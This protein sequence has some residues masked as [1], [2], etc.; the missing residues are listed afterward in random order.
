MIYKEIDGQNFLDMIITASNRLEEKKAYVDSLN[1]FPVP[2]GDTGTNMSM[3]F[4]AAVESIKDSKETSLGKISR[5]MAKGALMG[6]RG[7]SGVILSQIFR[8]IA[9]GFEN[10]EKADAKTLATAL[11]EGAQA[12]YRAVMRPTEGTILTVIREVGEKA[13]NYNEE[14]INSLME[15]VTVD[16]EDTLNRTPDLLPQLKEAKVVDSG[17]MGL[18]IIF[19]GMEE[20]LREGIKS[21]L[22]EETKSGEVSAEYGAALA[23]SDIKFGYCT[24]FIVGGA[25]KDPT[26]QPYLESMGDSIV[27]VTM[28]DVTKIHLHTENPGEVMQK[29]QKHGELLKIKIENMREQNRNLKPHEESSFVK[30]NLGN[31]TDN[32]KEKEEEVVEHKKYAFISVAA[33]DG[34]KSIFQDLGCDI[35]IEGGQTMNPSTQDIM[36][37][38]D[39]VKADHIFIFPNNK[40]IIMSANQVLEITD[41]NVTVIPTKTIPQGITCLASFNPESEFTEVKEFFENAISDVKSGAITFAVRDT[42][43]DGKNIKAGDYLGLLENKIKMVERDL[44]PLGEKLIEEMTKEDSSVISIY[45][46]K[47]VNKEEAEKFTEEIENKYKDY[48]VIALDGNQPIYYLLLSVE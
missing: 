45:F 16:A 25:I 43:I 7:N 46:G 44:F 24:E 22:R 34:L 6:A 19:K 3:T 27:F 29:A 12:A 21:T 48:D 1:V 17:G 10:V 26:F 38:I 37:A 20:A 41:K 8:G 28:D 36:N 30:E 31:T 5:D 2:D 15:K 13:V 18:L 42:E 32:E 47:D 14:S 9:K 33:G 23:P 11:S 40:N 39:K 35:V 4:R